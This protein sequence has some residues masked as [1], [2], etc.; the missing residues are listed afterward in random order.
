LLR[1]NRLGGAHGSTLLGRKV[2]FSALHQ[3]YGARGGLPPKIA[4]EECSQR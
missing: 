3:T 2:L 1:S 4:W